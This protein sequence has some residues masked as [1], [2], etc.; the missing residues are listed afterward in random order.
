MKS[1][2]LLMLKTRQLRVHQI[3]L[4]VE[5]FQGVIVLWLVV[6]SA[7]SLH[8]GCGFKSCMVHKN[9][10]SVKDYGNLLINIQP[11]CKNSEPCF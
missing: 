10:T 1:C 3:L 9:T 5:W 8:K 2:V 11:S 4:L 7:I 6:N